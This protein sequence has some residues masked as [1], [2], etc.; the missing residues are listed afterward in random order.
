MTRHFSGMNFKSEENLMMAVELV[1]VALCSDKDLPVR[2][3]AAIALQM[4]I[5]EQSKGSHDFSFSLRV[6]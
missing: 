4:I 5:T 2:V 3:E 6:D 1:K